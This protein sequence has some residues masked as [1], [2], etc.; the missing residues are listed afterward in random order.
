MNGKRNV[1]MDH[2]YKILRSVI[3]FARG[4]PLRTKS[5]LFVGTLLKRQVRGV[6]RCNLPTETL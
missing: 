3:G 2:R 4:S 6:Q 1:G 5:K